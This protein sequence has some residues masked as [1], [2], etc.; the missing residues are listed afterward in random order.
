MSCSDCKKT[1]V[2]VHCAHG[3]DNCPF[4]RGV[5]FSEK[6]SQETQFLLTQS[7]RCEGPESAVSLIIELYNN[8]NKEEMLKAVNSLDQI[9]EDAVRHFHGFVHRTI[10]CTACIISA[11]SSSLL[12]STISQ[13][14]TL[15]GSDLTCQTCSTP[16]LVEDLKLV[17]EIEKGGNF[18]NFEG[19]TLKKKEELFLDGALKITKSTRNH[20]KIRGRICRSTDFD[21]IIFHLKEVEKMVHT[22]D[23]LT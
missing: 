22:F 18:R 8:N 9:I 7:Q 23:N 19:I 12:T 15:E 3:W 1:L 17:R 14:G 21:R 5:N 16:V 4:C 2:H 20:F 10:A 6:S 11:S 13:Y